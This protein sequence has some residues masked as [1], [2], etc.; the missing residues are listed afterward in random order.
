M[1][2]FFARQ[3]S[4]YR[5][6]M[7]R[8]LAALLGIAQ[9]MLADGV[10]T[11][12]EIRFLDE[13]LTNNSAIATAWPGDLIHQ[14]V[15]DV[16]ADGI[17]TP[18]ERDH[19]VDTLQKLVGGRLEELANLTH[20]TELIFDE[21]PEIEFDGSVFC[22][23]GN[24]VYAPRNVCIKETVDRG[25]IV[26]SNVSK[27]LNYLVVGGLGSPEWKNGSFGTKIHKAMELKQKAQ[28]AI[29]HEDKWAQSL[30]G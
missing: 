4:A 14:R 23:T 21:V 3:A 16:L 6:E 24:F 19:L 29:V 18:E 26:K 20:V 5:N 12:A 13:W 30:F 1:D 7:N 28:I 15:R 25:G 11:D 17:V 10:L 27:K 2:N 8:S 22:L 9:G